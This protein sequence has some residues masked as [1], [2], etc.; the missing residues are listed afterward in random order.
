MPSSEL[1]ATVSRVDAANYQT[2]ACDTNGIIRL[3]C[4]NAGF[5]LAGMEKDKQTAVRMEAG[6]YRK[7]ERIARSLDRSVA[8]CIRAAIQAYIQANAK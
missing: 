6:E 2:G 3:T 1:W 7:L 8:W 4:G 5:T